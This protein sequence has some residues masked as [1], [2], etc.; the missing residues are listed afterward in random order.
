[1]FD[2]LSLIFDEPA[3]AV[4]A[5]VSTWPP[6]AYQRHGDDYDVV[7]HAPVTPTTCHA[8]ESFCS[9]HESEMD[10][11]MLPPLGPCTT[12]AAALAV[13]AANRTGAPVI[14]TACS[15]VQPHECAVVMGL[16]RLA[17]SCCRPYKVR[18]LL[19]QHVPV[20]LRLQDASDDTCAVAREAYECSEG[21]LGMTLRP[22]DTPAVREGKK[23]L[24]AACSGMHA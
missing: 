10:A 5:A 14:R 6:E 1:M 7:Q 21:R 19:R 18:F 22:S 15:S 24:L 8:C 13:A 9:Q 12:Y 16:S 4:A 17:T 20:L 2:H 23:R 3:G 11:A